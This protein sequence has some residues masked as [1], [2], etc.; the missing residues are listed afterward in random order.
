MAELQNVH[1]SVGANAFVSL[2]PSWFFY[3]LPDIQ[4][5]QESHHDCLQYALKKALHFYLV[6]QIAV[7]ILN[8]SFSAPLHCG[9]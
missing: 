4:V 3:N 2:P 5:V 6:F 7:L 1:S 9:E 8:L